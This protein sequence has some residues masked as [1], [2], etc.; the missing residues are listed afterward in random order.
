MNETN[1]PATDRPV[2][3]VNTQRI[4]MANSANVVAS[5][6]SRPAPVI[7]PSLPIVGQPTS[8]S[9]GPGRNAGKK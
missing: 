2:L 3:N 9:T 8:S 7:G 5:I 4:G 1:P 6:G